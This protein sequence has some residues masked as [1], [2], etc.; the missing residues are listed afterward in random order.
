MVTF[1]LVR[2]VL[3]ATVAVFETH[4]GVV[5]SGHAHAWCTGSDSCL[6]ETPV[7]VVVCG[8]ACAWRGGKILLL[9]TR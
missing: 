4:V 3:A 8:H 2:G 1:V 9:V 5:V 7:V 6:F